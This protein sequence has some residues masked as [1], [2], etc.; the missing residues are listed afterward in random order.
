MLNEVWSLPLYAMTAQWTKISRTLGMVYQFSEH[1]RET[2]PE[3][4]WGGRLR[5]RSPNDAHQ[6]SDWR[7]LKFGRPKPAGARHSAL[8][9]VSVLQRFRG[10]FLCISNSL[11][12][13]L[14]S[15]STVIFERG[16]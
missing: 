16:Q 3:L 14:W 15:D 9:I 12:E 4:T 8:N 1:F 6:R 5:K 7:G 13:S 11:T 2:S 10:R